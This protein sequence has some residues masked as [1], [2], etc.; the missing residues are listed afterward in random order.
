[1]AMISVLMIPPLLLKVILI[2][3]H[4]IHFTVL[5]HVMFSSLFLSYAFYFLFFVLLFHCLTSCTLSLYCLS[6]CTVPGGL[7]QEGM[8]VV[9]VPSNTSSAFLQ[10]ASNNTRRDV[11]TCGILAGKFVSHD[12]ALYIACVYIH[13]QC[14][15]VYNTNI[16]EVCIRYRVVV[17]F[18]TVS[19]F[20]IVYFIQIKVYGKLLGY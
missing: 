4:Y 9:S 19:N 20:I 12:V 16:V 6:S 13:V 15:L 3:E 7:S 10:L 1:M 8:R 11:E 2:H 5:V 17:C 18:A 14:I